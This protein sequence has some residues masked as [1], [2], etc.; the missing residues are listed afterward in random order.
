MPTPIQFYITTQ[1]PVNDLDPGVVAQGY[2]VASGNLIT[3]TDAAGMALA[4]GWNFEVESEIGETA[5]SVAQKVRFSLKLC[6]ED[7]LTRV[8]RVDL[9]RARQHG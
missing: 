3:L 7:Q 1:K 6:R 8:R 4:G 9:D 5:H 2:Y